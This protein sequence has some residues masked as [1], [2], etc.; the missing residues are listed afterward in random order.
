M[1]LFIE[2]LWKEKICLLGSQWP[3][4]AEP[5]HNY[6]P[7][8]AAIS[9]NKQHPRWK[10]VLAEVKAPPG[11][12]GLFSGNSTETW[13]NRSPAAADWVD[14]VTNCLFWLLTLPRT[15]SLTNRLSLGSSLCSG[16]F[17]VSSAFQHLIAR[18][19]TYAII[20]CLSIS[21]SLYP[22]LSHTIYLPLFS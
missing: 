2:L 17:K 3:S 9:E 6:C 7:N 22:S 1:G 4:K 10:N 16:R 12:G 14:D 20:I 13:K 5:V 19:F 8:K 15:T 21:F 11:Q 18:N